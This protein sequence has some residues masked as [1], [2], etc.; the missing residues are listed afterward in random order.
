VERYVYDP[1]GK[2]TVTKYDG[3]LLD[4]NG[5]CNALEVASAYGN[6]FCWTGQRYDPRVGL[7]HFWFRSYSPALGRWL[8]RDPVGYVDSTDLY[9]CD[10]SNP[11]DL[12][13]PFGLSPDDGQS[14]GWWFRLIYGPVL[15][16]TKEGDAPPP[17]PP[18]GVKNFKWDGECWTWRPGEF[19]GD[20]PRHWDSPTRRLYVDG[21]IESKRLGPKSRSALSNKMRKQLRGKGIVLLAGILA[22]LI[23]EFADALDQFAEPD[24]PCSNWYKA[25]LANDCWAM[26]RLQGD[27]YDQ[28]VDA[29]MPDAALHFS[30]YVAPKALDACAKREADE[31]RA[32]GQKE[33]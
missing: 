2:T 18:G 10:L 12:V 22:G 8:E 9:E 3:V 13:D 4:P 26:E 27:C 29:K 32:R 33:K 30:K 19:T 7:Y 20:K 6:P 28:L 15:Y 31:E 24:T 11:V 23:T 1:Y 16:V 21:T 17:E 25:A 14:W 5:D